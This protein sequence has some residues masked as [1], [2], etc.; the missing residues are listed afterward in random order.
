V[1]SPV[2][3]SSYPDDVLSTTTPKKTTVKIS[4][5]DYAVYLQ[6]ASGWTFEVRA[7]G[8]IS[9]AS[10]GRGVES[11]ASGAYLS[12]REQR[13]FRGKKIVFELDQAGE[14]KRTYYINGKVNNV[15][16]SAEG[17]IS[18]SVMKV[19]YETSIGAT[20]RAKHI[21]ATEGA[22]AL[23]R[24][25]R[26]LD[27]N[28]QRQIYLKI[29]VAADLMDNVAAEAVLLAPEIISSSSS[30][31]DYLVSVGRKYSKS[32]IMSQALFIAAGEIES[33]SELRK[34]VEELVSIVSINDE[35]GV[36]MADAI[37]NI[38]SSTE[39]ATAISTV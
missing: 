21:L 8:D 3:G 31:G 34:T 7:R 2:I 11:M 22:E 16:Q 35:A 23:L 15:D 14:I 19:I 39:K 10:D 25:T 9:F 13:H 36:A 6:T 18:E 37:T 27:S 28:E 5:D 20:S 1:A 32:A 38:S 12:I 17:W 26:K 29:L 33:S 4:A 24:A 30:L